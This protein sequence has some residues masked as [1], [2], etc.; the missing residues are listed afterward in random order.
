MYVCLLSRYEAAR[1]PAQ[2]PLERS[3]RARGRRRRR[4]PPP[5]RAAAPRS[6]TSCDPELNAALARHS[7]ARAAAPPPPLS[8]VRRERGGGRSSRIHNGR[9]WPVQTER[10]S[11]KLER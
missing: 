2:G 8:L 7:A 5:G 10:R 3:T 6:L 4:R 9:P 11:T 1:P